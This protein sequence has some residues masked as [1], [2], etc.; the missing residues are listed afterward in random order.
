MKVRKIKLRQVIEQGL[1]LRDDEKEKMATVPLQFF[2]LLNYG[3]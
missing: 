3:T 1:K 2:R